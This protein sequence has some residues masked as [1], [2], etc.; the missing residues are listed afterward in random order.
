MIFSSTSAFCSHPARSQVLLLLGLQFTE[1]CALCKCEPDGELSGYS[2]GLDYSA[3][4]RIDGGKDK[5][6]ILTSSAEPG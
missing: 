2:S 4:T 3:V 5:P 1:V 6:G